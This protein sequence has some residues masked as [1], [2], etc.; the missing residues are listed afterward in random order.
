MNVFFYFLFGACAGSF[1]HVVGYRLPT[2]SYFSSARSKC[3]QCGHT[4]RSYELIPLISYVFL[5]GKCST[6]HTGISLMYPAS[7]MVCGGLFVLAYMTF[8]HS[9][10]LVFALLFVALLFVLAVCDIYYY[11]LP[12]VLVFLLFMLI[13]I[14]TLRSQH[15]AF[16]ASLMSVL[17]SLLLLGLLIYFTEG[18]M[19]LGDFKLLA[20]LA[21]FFGLQAYLQL[22][23]LSSL[24]AIIYYLFTAWTSKKTSYIFFGPFIALA[25]CLLLFI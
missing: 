12:N 24:L 15:I 17:F 22:L 3:P 2:G 14:W 9:L 21:Y 5:R 1:L 10:N 13:F 25:A 6:C 11:I 18:G 16:L 8:G 23:F 7:E 19:G 20:V 4:L